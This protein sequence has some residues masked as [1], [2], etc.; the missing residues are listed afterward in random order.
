VCH[1][2][3]PALAI[4]VVGHIAKDITAKKQLNLLLIT[5]IISNSQF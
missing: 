4:G 1:L 2:A 5:T 3:I